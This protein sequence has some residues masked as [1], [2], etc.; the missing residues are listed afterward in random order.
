MTTR[1]Q[2]TQPT[3]PLH[4]SGL[5]GSRFVA[6]SISV[7]PSSLFGESKWNMS[8]LVSTPGIP[9]ND[10]SWDFKSVP[11]YPEGF[12]LSLA[13][14]AYARLYK[15]VATHDRAGTWLTVLNELGILNG[16]AKYCADQGRGGFHE[17]DNKLLERYLNYISLS[18]H[19]SG[20]RIRTIFRIIYR[21]WEYR[22]QI[23]KP[24]IEKPFSKPFEDMFPGKA[25]GA[26]IENKTP[27]IPEP[28]YS[29]IMRAALDYVLEY[30]STILKTWEKVQHAWDT[31]IEPLNIG[32]S[33]KNKR[34]TVIAK[35]I[36][37]K[38]DSHWRTIPMNSHGDL[39]EELQQLRTACTLTILAYS[40]IRS[41]ELL[42]LKASCYVTD[43]SVDGR[44]IFYINTVLHKHRE[45][46]SKDTWVVIE[47]VV[48]AIQIAEVLTK[49]IRD[50]ASDERLM[51]TD[52]SNSLFNVKKDFS[53]KKISEISQ[54]AV[55][56]QLNSFREHCNHK[57]CRAPIPE[58][59]NDQG[60]LEPW[61][62]NTRQFRRTLA[63]YIARQPFG[64]IAGMLQYKHIEV[65]IFEGY[66]GSEPEWN[67][68]L[69]QEKVLASVDILDE[70]AMDLSQ[71]M[72]AGEFGI[73]LQSK[74]N[75]EFKGRAED[76]PPSQIAKW[77]AS[78][79]KQLFVGKFNLCFFDPTKALC[80]SKIDQKDR[81]I[82]NFCQPDHC[83][84]ACVAQRHIPFWEA[85]RNQAKDC[86]EH[87]KTSIYQRQILEAEI[88]QLDSVI[89]QI[90]KEPNA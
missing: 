36:I 55:V 31:E 26:D 87:A 12:A 69:E 80:T 54:D 49:R 78:T 30:S 24:I 76:F 42:S 47:E 33:G 59:L 53:G 11:G 17:I 57:L 74:F 64:I 51:L 4:G 8:A 15:P 20:E 9:E 1:H 2:Y 84:N 19:K 88:A 81:P 60:E 89:N 68:L 75:A 37:E 35:R 3:L 46:G 43:T 23:T 86:S 14:Y 25:S 28:I 48:K 66:A 16:F 62:F 29:S 65:T 67:K 56:Y 50:A 6:P 18:E 63:R 83:G 85:Q 77:L 41:T 21:L 7:S 79:Q 61:S 27:V 10:K 58:W 40:G 82:L 90:R 32:V 34:F 38:A 73:H 52:G 70:L 13:E 22:S 44:P 71:G 5:T 72:V 45:G 39:Y